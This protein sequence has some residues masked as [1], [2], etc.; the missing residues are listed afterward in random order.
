LSE[1]GIAHLDDV[2]TGRHFLGWDRPALP[3]TVDWLTPGAEA[4]GWDLSQLLLVV[5]AAR[6]TRRLMELLVDAAGGALPG[7]PEIV[8]LGQLPEQ[9]FTPPE[10]VAD[11]RAAMLARATTLRDAPPTEREPLIPRPPEDHDWPGWWA[12]AE[13][14]HAISRDL[15]AHRLAVADVATRCDERG[16]ELP[17]PQRWQALAAMETRYH[18]RL[19]DAGL[20]DPQQARLAAARDG[21]CRCDR[22]VVLIATADVSPLVA[23]M[24]DQLAAPVTALVHAPQTHAPGFDA[25]GGLVVDYWQKQPVE[26]DEARLRFAED[27]TQQA[28]SAGEAIREAHETK[29]AE[30]G[31][32]YAVDE[33]TV[34]LGDEAQADSVRRTLNL[35]GLA[36]RYGPGSALS[37]ARPAVLLTALGRFARNRRFDDLAALL[38]HP[39]IEPYLRSLDESPADAAMSEAAD[40]GELSHAREHWLV[41]LD[42][43]AQTHLQGRVDGT[44]LGDPQDRAR[45]KRLWGAITALLPHDPD[46]RR[47]LPEWRESIAEALDRVYGQWQLD[48]RDTA[49]DQLWR[50]LEAISQIL[51]EHAELA[52]VET[53]APR[54]TWAE[55]IALL[56]RQWAGASL[57]EPGGE[58]AVELMGYLDLAMDDAPV[59]VVTS[60]NEG[61]V[62]AARNSDPMLPNDLRRR[63]GLADNDHRAARDGLRLKSILASRAVVTLLAARH[64]A[65]GDPLAPSRLLLTGDDT[66]LIE[67]LERFYTP[68]DAPSTG[69]LLTPGKSD[70]FRIPPPARDEALPNKLRVTAFA[71]YLA[72]PYRFYLKHVRRLDELEDGNEEMDPPTFG[73]LMHDVL[74]RFGGSEWRASDDPAAIEG[75]LSDALDRL[76]ARHFGKDNSHV[77]VRLQIEQLRQRLR[78]FAF[79]HAD[80]IAKG[81]QL[82]ATERDLEATVHVDGQ[83]FVLTGRIDR[84]DYHPEHGYRILDYKTADRPKTPRSTHHRKSDNGESGWCDLQL[85]LYH[86]LAAASGIEDGMDLGYFNLPKRHEDAGV[87]TANW[88][89]DDLE[90]ARIQRDAVIRAIRDRKF[91]PPNEPPNRADAYTRIC[92]DDVTQRHA[93]IERSATAAPEEM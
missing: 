92:A 85:P 54:V 62:P 21:V 36:T 90:D 69:S 83:P 86:V 44:W 84:I 79:I 82:I 1:N 28:R 55:A 9:L 22:H 50:S 87:V 65:S 39:D 8:T 59:T 70:R 72:C 41:L 15:A 29:E 27:P 58:P 45:L 6:A 75:F 46:A 52:G 4:L 38:R 78:D 25:L 49:D 34:G 48:R 31:R 16:I 35:M 37:N 91:W 71:D 13:S 68:D 66:T 53:L 74:H 93:L 61:C 88:D 18:A 57:P 5:P 3:A 80:E 24:L 64:S 14:F 12:L 81:W 17:H 42:R 7:P 10:P 76:A 11:E 20:R 63:L 67:R 56:S 26:V 89:Q 73:S 43:Y 40:P 2:P 60:L 19:A 33:I 77:A 47:P 30:E 32:G 51:S 23:G